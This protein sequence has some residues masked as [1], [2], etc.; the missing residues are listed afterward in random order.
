MV[1]GADLIGPSLAVAS[2]DVSNTGRHRLPIRLMVALLYLK[3]AYN[4]SDESLVER[5]AQ[6]VHFQLFCGQ[7]Y[8]EPRLACDPAQISRFRRVLGSIGL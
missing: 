8:F 4:E 1:E 3:H 5:W 7:V 2:A 6:D